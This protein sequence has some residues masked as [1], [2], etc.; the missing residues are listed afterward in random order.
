MIGEQYRK[1]FKD[2]EMDITM[3]HNDVV[4]HEESAYLSR[5]RADVAKEQLAIDKQ[6]FEKAKKDFEY[7]LNANGG[8]DN[9]TG[10]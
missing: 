10:L 2:I 8:T 1:W 9:G 3:A 5:K 7:Y 4:Y 6:R